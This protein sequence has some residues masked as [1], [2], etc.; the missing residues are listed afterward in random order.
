MKMVKTLIVHGICKQYTNWQRENEE[1]CCSFQ[2]D[3]FDVNSKQD[4]ALNYTVN[5]KHC[6]KVMFGSSKPLFN[7]S[8]SFLFFLL[9]CI[10]CDKKK[11]DIENLAQDI[12]ESTIK[13][14]RW[15]L[16]W[17]MQFT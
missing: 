15:I 3:V 16:D 17:Y 6:E 11:K 9:L 12:C 14:L 4:S 5:C 7:E 13:F 10:R 8:K 2:P 1:I